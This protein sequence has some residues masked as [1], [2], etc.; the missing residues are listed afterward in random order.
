L[1]EVPDRFSVGDHIADA[2]VEE[3]FK[4]RAVKDWLLRGVVA[5]PVEV[6]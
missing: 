4:A 3:A 5:E 2:Q 1:L 6:L